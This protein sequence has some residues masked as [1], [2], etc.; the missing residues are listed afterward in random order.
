LK[1]IETDEAWPT[2]R[3]ENIAFRIGDEIDQD[4]LTVSWETSTK[5]EGGDTRRGPS[6]IE[7]ISFIVI[8]ET[9]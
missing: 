2:G 4:W 1:V 5:P 8:G 9:V 7:E 3:V 6:E